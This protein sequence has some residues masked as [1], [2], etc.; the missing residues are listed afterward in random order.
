MLKPRIEKIAGGT[1]AQPPSG[2][3]VLKP[4]Y[5]VAYLTGDQPAAFRRLCVETSIHRRQATRHRPAAFRRLCVETLPSILKRYRHS[6]PPS[7][8]CV[9]K[10]G[11]CRC[12]GILKSQPPSGGCVLK[13]GT[14]GNRIARVCQPPSGGCVLKRHKNDLCRREQGPAAFR[15]LCVETLP[16]CMSFLFAAP[17][18]FRRLCVETLPICMSFLFAAPAAFRRLCVET[19]LDAKLPTE[20]IQPPSGGCVLKHYKTL[21]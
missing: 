15:R 3:C 17:A 7:G 16:I 14:F 2:G 4:L 20:S 21:F 6:Q 5:Q 19:F 11:F 10:Q 13:Q 18:A 12:A 8:G 9:L 1:L